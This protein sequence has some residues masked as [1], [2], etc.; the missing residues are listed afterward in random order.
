MTKS[1]GLIRLLIE[2]GPALS[3]QATA[4]L[5]GEVG[6]HAN[7]LRVWWRFHRG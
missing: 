2:V 3:I 7:A 4:W 6:D 1:R 5:L